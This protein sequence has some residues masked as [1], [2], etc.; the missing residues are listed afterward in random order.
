MGVLNTHSLD[1]ERLDIEL[2]LQLSMPDLALPDTWL[3]CLD[4]AQLAPQP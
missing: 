3:C 1:A 2:L 4:T